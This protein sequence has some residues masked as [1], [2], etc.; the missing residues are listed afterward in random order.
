[1]QGDHSSYDFWPARK[2][3]LVED[4]PRLVL[5]AIN[6]RGITRLAVP[7]VERVFVDH[8]YKEPS[9]ARDRIATAFVYSPTG[10]VVN[11]EWEIEGLW[12]TTIGASDAVLFGDRTPRALRVWARN[13]PAVRE[14]T[15]LETHLARWFAGFSALGASRGLRVLGMRLAAD[16]KP[17]E[18]ETWQSKLRR[19]RQAFRNALVGK[20]EHDEGLDE[21]VGRR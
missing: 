15:V 16:L 9:A 13:L 19:T 7:E 12:K 2:E 8:E 20:S 4:D 14:R 11:P 5:A 21:R 17:K 10:R 6:D 1:M 18:N 3:V